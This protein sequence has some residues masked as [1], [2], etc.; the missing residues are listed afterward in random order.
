MNRS[1]NDSANQSIQ[2]FT[3]LLDKVQK[4]NIIAGEI[5][6]RLSKI[7]YEINFDGLDIVRKINDIASLIAISD[8]D[9]A[10]ASKILYNAPNNWEKIYSI[11]SAYLTIFEVFKTYNKHRKFLNEISISS[12]IFLNEEFKNINNL[13]KAFKN[14]HRYDNEMSVIR[15]NI[16]GHISDNIELY[17]NTIIQF[18]GEKTGEMIIEFLQILDI[19][20]N[21][22]IKIL[23]QE[24]LK[25]NHQEI[26]KLARKMFPD[27]NNKI[28]LL[29]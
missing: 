7:N 12:S 13:I 8:L 6:V 9:L 16:C 10:V 24:K 15:N 29:F 11:K 26:I 28:N 25:Y 17:Y 1:F 20:Q 3:N 22:L 23:E 18:N 4:S 2:V 14:K 27:L 21:F 5:K 19:L